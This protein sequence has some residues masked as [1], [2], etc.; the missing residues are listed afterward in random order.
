MVGGTFL[1]FS[2]FTFSF[3]FFSFGMTERGEKNTNPYAN[4]DYIYMS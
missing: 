2:F 3:P 1:F 4:L